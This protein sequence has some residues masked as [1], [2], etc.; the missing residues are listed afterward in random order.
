[1]YIHY[2]ELGADDVLAMHDQGQRKINRKTLT[3]RPQSISSLAA[4][5]ILHDF[6]MVRD[7]NQMGIIIIYN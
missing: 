4:K 3:G 7:V 1:M 5:V 2:S 6:F